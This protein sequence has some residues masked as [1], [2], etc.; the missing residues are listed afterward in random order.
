MIHEDL[1]IQYIKNNDL[2]NVTLFLKDKKIKANYDN[3]YPIILSSS[4]GHIDIVRLLLTYEEVNPSAAEK[5]FIDIVKLLLEDKRINMNLDG[6]IVLAC[7]KGHFDIY[8][9][10][11]KYNV[12][13]SSDENSCIR[14][15]YEY[16]NNT[17][18]LD[19]LWQDKRIKNSLKNDDLK[20]YNKLIKKDIKEKVESF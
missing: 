13:P 10:F 14:S 7:T 6:A 20:L 1:F 4:F 15:V 9:L 11:L 5:G 12:D 3:N 16:S 17:A 19:L 8:D 18:M 2:K